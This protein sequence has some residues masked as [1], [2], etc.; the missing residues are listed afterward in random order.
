M[1]RESRQFGV[2]SVV[3]FHVVMVPDARTVWPQ[4]GRL[5][6]GSLIHTLRRAL[7][8][9]CWFEEEDAYQ[10]RLKLPHGTSS[11]VRNYKRV[12]DSCEIGV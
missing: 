5:L 1:L 6:M 4:Q 3:F 2:L 8:S 9:F 12:Q 10:I 7:V 11:T